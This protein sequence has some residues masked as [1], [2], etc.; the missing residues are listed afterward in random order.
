MV[1][2]RSLFGAKQAPL[3]GIDISASSVKLVELSGGRRDG[4]ITLE[5][6]AI[7]RLEKGW[8]SE[9]NIENFD[10]V[11]EALR[12][13][14]K[15][16]GTRTRNAALAL[17]SSAVITRKIVLPSGLSEEELEIQV[18]SEASHYI[19][20]SL[21]EVSLDF[22]V[23]GPSKS[24]SDDVEVLIAASRKDRVQD[25][26]GLA[27]AAG[28]KAVILDIE[29]YASHL[30]VTRLAQAWPKS[31]EAPIVA[32]FEIGAT[33]ST[34]L[35]VQGDDLLFEREQAFGGAQLTQAI[36][37]HYGI[38]VEEA[39]NK[40]RAGEMP[41]DY[42]AAVLRPFVNNLTQEVVRALQLF[43]TSTPYN[44]VD[45]ILLAGGTAIVNGL[46]AAVTQATETVCQ[47]A[48][49]FEG[50]EMGGSVRMKS[51]MREAPSYLTACGLAL[52][53]FDQ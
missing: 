31:A 17:P 34:M 53:R 46:A 48:S 28:L 52:R 22:C 26:Q 37:R 44:A 6:A 15:K 30:A 49:P 18:E 40:K 36:S 14:I 13:L 1:A 33:S 5:R 21:D 9:G 32:V 41:D 7:E 35:V 11:A 42:A 50:M 51:V 47:V 29:S 2:A 8:V 4:K 19:P 38:S 25:R 12:R 39:E 3:L 43:F 16:S 20:F 27:E 45:R 24:S 10:E 23:V